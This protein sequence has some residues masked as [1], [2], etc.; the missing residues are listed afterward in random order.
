M[1]P[2]RCVTGWHYVTLAPKSLQ[3]AFFFRNMSIWEWYSSYPV[4]LTPPWF[5]LMTNQV[6]LPPCTWTWLTLP[7]C[8]CRRPPPPSQ[9]RRPEWPPLPPAPWQLDCSLRLSQIP[10]R[11][12]N[13]PH[14][15]LLFLLLQRSARTRFENI[16]VMKYFGSLFS[17]TCLIYT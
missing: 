11:F 5:D 17:E 10:A 6:S 12:R 8:C 7:C 2:M 13:L 15:R 4:P 16:M 9:R 3:H 14:S 1:T